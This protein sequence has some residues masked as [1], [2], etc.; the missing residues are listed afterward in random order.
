ME[1]EY[2]VL[3]GL[4]CTLKRTRTHLRFPYASMA[5][6][7]KTFSRTL[8]SSRAEGGGP[9]TGVGVRVKGGG[10]HVESIGIGGE[11]CSA[12]EVVVNERGSR[13]TRGVVE[14]FIHGVVLE[15]DKV[16]CE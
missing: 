14:P 10:S 4:D 11:G 2:A 16:C 1:I 12:G 3:G 7:C 5:T 8:G 6:A 9:P 15:G 13:S